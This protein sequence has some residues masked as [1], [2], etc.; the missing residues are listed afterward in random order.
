V[1]RFAWINRARLKAA[2][3]KTRRQV[4]RPGINSA[5][6]KAAATKPGAS[7]VRLRQRTGCQR[8]KG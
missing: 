6:L 1:L 5:R 2:G 7:W 3:Y 4:V 8:R